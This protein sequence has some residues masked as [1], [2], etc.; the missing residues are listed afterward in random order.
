MSEDLVTI[1]VDGRFI[2]AKKGQMLIQATDDAGIYI[3][4]FCY[5]K[6]LSVAANCRM[7]L[8]DMEKAPKPVPA[9]ATPIADGMKFY[10]QSEKA[11]SAQKATMEFLLIN[12]PLDCPICDQGGECE[13]QDL[14]LGYGG[15]VSQYHERKRI[16][17]DENLGPLIATEMTRCIHCTRCVRFGEEIAGMRELAATGR[18]EHMRIGTYVGKTVE[19]EMSGNVIDLCPVGAL[20]ARPS[21]YTARPWEL[22][23]I[24][25]I[26]PH[27]AVGANLNAHVRRGQLMRV[28]PK[29][30]EAINETW[31]S[32]RDRFSY[33][34]I[35]SEDRL[36]SPM[37]RRGNVWEIVSW[38]VALKAAADALRSVPGQALG[39]LASPNATVEELYLFR[40]LADGLGCA[41]IDHRFRQADFS[42]QDIAPSFPSLGQTLAELEQNKAVLIVGSNLRKEIPLVHHRLRKAQ[43]NGAKISV[44]NSLNGDFRL[45]LFEHVIAKDLAEQ[46]AAVA[47]AAAELTAKPIPKVLTEVVQGIVVD[48]AHIRIVQSLIETE[49][50]SVILGQLI[51]D[52]PGFAVIRALSGFISQVTGAVLG[53]LPSG[54]NAAGAWLAGVVPHR[55]PGGRAAA[56]SGKHA[57]AMFAEPMRGYLLLDLE[58][59]LDI[60]DAQQSMKA[61]EG[62]DVVVC[63]SP[64]F[65]EAMRRYAKVV[66]PI[67]TFAETSGTL[68]NIEGR[69]QSFAGCAKPIGEARPAWKV[70]RV[71]GN[72]FGL[73]GFDFESSEAV[74]TQAKAAIGSIAITPVI[75]FSDQPMTRKTLP[76]WW[77]LAD[78]PIYATDS[79]VR[80]AAS[81][82][83][84]PDMEAARHVHLHPEDA[85]ALRVSTAERVVLNQGG[86][87]VTLPLKLD[88][89][90]AR[91][92]VR[93]AAGLVETRGLGPRFGAI[94]IEPC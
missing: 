39:M 47:L 50:A 45:Q 26:S 29:E 57:A 5:H 28:V 81:L 44:I 7:C 90:L 94:T 46:L 61:L 64:F 73:N 21:R 88:A 37:V 42:D 71:L 68:I 53:Y 6:K 19:H 76:A 35:A 9:C 11:I 93:V 40:R 16:V 31:I 60:A 67:G 63:L 43:K 66:L 23:S 32:D 79:L 78:V 41:H 80:R 92:C 8:V 56:A 14:A 24:P 38:E 77:R 20:T 58:P 34:G 69:W 54:G 33:Q 91:G 75:V 25:T 27:D 49:S 1:E 65:T 59:E 17:Q 4:R 82:Q 3:P 62:A 13:L 52:Q 2:Q 83:A 74:L 89:G 70:L 84:T 18:G 30:N 15:D 12:H 51:Q 87:R 72:Q 55:E 36:K 22:Q 48:G 86:Y 85:E 10:T